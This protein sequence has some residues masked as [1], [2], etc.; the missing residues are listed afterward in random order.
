MALGLG[1]GLATAL[2]NVLGLLLS[3]LAE[4]AGTFT[5]ITKAWP[6]L[7]L[8]LTG[9]LFHWAR[10][11]GLTLRRLAKDATVSALPARMDLRTLIISG[12]NVT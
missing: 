6:G 2:G 7:N 4:P 8:A 5:N 11:A 3:L 10:L 9:T 12:V 1:A